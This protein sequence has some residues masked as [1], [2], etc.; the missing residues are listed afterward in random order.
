MHSGFRCSAVK[1]QI[2]PHRPAVP[3]V[4]AVPAA[5]I[6]PIVRRLDYSLGG[7]LGVW[8]GDRLNRSVDIIIGK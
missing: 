3:A 8:L 2:A 7:R 6:D 1:H 5:A 4:P